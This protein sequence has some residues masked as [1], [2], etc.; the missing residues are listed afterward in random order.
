MVELKHRRNISENLD[1]K[2]SASAGLLNW[3]AAC[4]S[5]VRRRVVQASSLGGILNSK[6]PLSHVVG[7]THA[8]F[9]V[10]H[11]TQPSRRSFHCLHVF[12]L[13]PAPSGGHHS[14]KPCRCSGYSRSRLFPRPRTTPTLLAVLDKPGS[15]PGDPWSTTSS[16]KSG[17]SNTSSSA[18]L[19]ALAMVKA[20]PAVAN[21]SHSQVRSLELHRYLVLVATAAPP[22]NGRA[23][24]R[25]ERLERF[26]WHLLAV[27]C[28]IEQGPHRS[29]TLL[30][31]LWLPLGREPVRR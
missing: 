6:P 10:D 7:R 20:T 25:S 5:Q 31:L 24:Q 14:G 17:V 9:Y 27:V 16:A 8:I 21:Q 1:T 4:V 23:N 15:G 19:A 12:C 26:A 11:T 2:P 30:L 18:P 29:T 22:E 3:V 28:T 13:P